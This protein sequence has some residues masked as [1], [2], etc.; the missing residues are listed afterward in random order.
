MTRREWS[1]R[2]KACALIAAL[3]ATA[4]TAAASPANAAGRY[5]TKNARF[6]V[7]LT[8]TQTSTWSV[9]RRD[10][11]EVCGLTFRGSGRQTI[12]WRPSVR[13]PSM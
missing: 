3:T 1:G 7:A 8:A 4:M 13:P 5:K 10:P 9:D 11:F 6:K 12:G 2:W